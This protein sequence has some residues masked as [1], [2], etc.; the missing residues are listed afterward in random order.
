MKGWRLNLKGCSIK[1]EFVY[2]TDLDRCIPVVKLPFY[3]AR[4]PH[5]VHRTVDSNDRVYVH[6]IVMLI[7]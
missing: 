3:S 1:R 6:E 2:D 5:H 4:V 7:F